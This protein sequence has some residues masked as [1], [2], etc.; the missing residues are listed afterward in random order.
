MNIYVYIERLILDGLPI[1]TGQGVLVQA[2]VEAELA[3]L[4][5][6][7]G[8]APNLQSGG[9]LPGLRADAIQVTAQSSPAQMGQAIAQSVYTGIG[10]TR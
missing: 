2:A 10:K 7:G 5:V 4:L 3:R 8:L 1:G 6:Q 9:A